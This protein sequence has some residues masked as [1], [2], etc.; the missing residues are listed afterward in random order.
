MFGGKLPDGITVVIGEGG[1]HK[2]TTAEIRAQTA[3]AD[4]ISDSSCPVAAKSIYTLPQLSPVALAIARITQ[5]PTAL[6]AG[7]GLKYCIR[8]PPT[9]KIFA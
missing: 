9:T 1:A 8:S 6:P 3:L 5:S 4:G 2:S 7:F